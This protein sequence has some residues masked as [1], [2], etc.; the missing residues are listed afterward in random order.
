MSTEFVAPPAVIFHLPIQG[1]PADF[2]QIGGLGPV[3]SSLGK[4]MALHYE[5]HKW[6]PSSC[7]GDTEY[8]VTDMRI[9]E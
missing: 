4:C 9:M 8:Y 6:I 2:E 3:T 1:R 5:Q 7:F